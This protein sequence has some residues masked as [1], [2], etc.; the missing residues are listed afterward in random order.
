MASLY[1]SAS[2]ALIPSGVKDGK[3]FSIKPTDGSGDFT[4]SRGTGTATRVNASGLIEK[5]R[6]N[7][8][9]QS[10]QFDTNWSNA[11]TTETSGQ[12]GYDGSNDAWLLSK[13]ASSFAYI[14]QN[15]SL[16]G[17]FTFSCYAKA[18]TLSQINLWTNTA[19]RGFFDLSAGTS[20]LGGV[21]TSIEA[22]GGGW[23]RC[24]AVFNESIS[25]VRISPDWSAATAGTIYIQD[26]QL[27][28]GLV[29]TDYI[30]TTTAAVYEGITDNLPRLDYSGGA[31][32]PSLLLEPSRTNLVAQSEYF[33]ASDWGIQNASLDANNTTSV[34]GLQN[35][36]KITDDSNT[37]YHKISYLN[38]FVADGV[39]R[40]WSLFVKQGNAR[41]CA[42]SNAAVFSSPVNSL[43]FDMQEGVYTNEGTTE[44]FDI[45]HEPID[46]GNGWWRIGFS[47]DLNSNSYDNFSIGISQGADWSA[48][49]SYTGDGSLDFYIYGAQLEAG[50][51]PTS[52]IPTYGT[53][54]SRAAETANRTG[55]SSNVFNNDN[56]TLFFDFDY[57]VDGREGPTTKYRIFSDSSQ[58]GIKGTNNNSRALQVF[59]SG[60][61]S[62]EINFN[63]AEATRI[64]IAL[65]VTDGTCEL[66][67]N[68]AKDTET[69]DVSAAAPY[70][71]GQ[72]TI[73]SD[74]SLNTSLNQCLGFPT[75]L[76]DA[77]CI[78]LTT[79]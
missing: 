26:A 27:E 62:G 20:S 40:T 79:I 70:S 35:A 53:A 78:A 38:A 15:V 68:G 24:S 67:F 13:N 12:S 71:W 31:S 30:E 73:L 56:L 58:L 69:I 21:T 43:I 63:A 32:C 75:A 3:V 61:F 34:E 55:L 46:M 36:Y 48:N 50:S 45:V 19:T 64:K 28:Q 25:Q 60:D 52:Y 74:N 41:Y 49:L 65:R 66:F 23:Y 72:V 4:F 47:S 16:S 29:A 77:E 9:L 51:Y 7:V 76:T 5:E 54:A 37:G 6:G 59:S 18:G 1:D 2:L 44:Y 14:Y 33:G 39:M 10:N 8:L 57:N 22:V 11:N 42:I 17:V